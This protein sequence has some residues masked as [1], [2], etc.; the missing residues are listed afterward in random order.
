MKNL[1]TKTKKHNLDFTLKLHNQFIKPN[2][3][4]FVNNK[5]SLD[6]NVNEY[7]INNLEFRDNADWNF[8]NPADII[9]LGCSHTY[10]VGIPQ[11]YIWPEIIKSKT[12]QTVAN[13]GIC[14][15]SAQTMLDSFLLYLDKVGNPKYVLAC[16][17]DHL[18]YS[19]VAD[20]VF[21]ALNN[22][23]DNYR[24]KKIVTHTRTSDYDNGNINIEDKIIKLPAD[25][26]YTIPVEESLSQYISSIYIIEKVCQFLNIKFYWSTWHNPTKN[27]F[28]DNLFL[29][30][31][32][33]LNR[34]NFIENISSQ[35]LANEFLGPVDYE[36]ERN[37]VIDHKMKSEDFEKYNSM[38]DVASDKKHLGVHWHYHVAESFIKWIH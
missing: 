4:S 3:I 30:K 1:H 22:G 11:K 13:L 31:D 26:R 28:L 24:S 37:C 17:P 27:I 23:G 21:F 32:F 20:S 6:N 18:R 33:C 34:I 38:W 35:H 36:D 19:H 29:Q 14:G 12:N 16:F 25:P 10:G 2:D 15:A 8:G 7:F 5:T 9:A